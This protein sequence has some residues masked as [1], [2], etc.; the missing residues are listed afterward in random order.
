MSLKLVSA[1]A[2]EPLSLNDAK[3]HLRVDG[4]DEDS[5]I[6]ALIQFARE[7]IEGETGRAL[8]TQTWAYFLDL[9]P[10]TFGIGWW[11]GVRLGPIASGA[12]RIVVLPKP[13]LQSVTH[14]K[15]YDS[16]DQPTTFS[17]TLYI[18]DV[19]S[20]PARISL[21][22]GATWPVVGRAINGIEIEFVAGYGNG[23]SDVVGPLRQAMQLLV[24]H[25]FEN[26]EL[27]GDQARPPSQPLGIEPLLAPFH[28]VGL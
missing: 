28:R 4:T 14:I 20:M 16:D 22:K 8:I 19:G 13:P 9:W 10:E 5:Y 21:R 24:A 3:A 27:T 18:V 25:W 7:F 6:S 2:A 23:A 26:R 11:D 15:T 12:H 17:S 1:P